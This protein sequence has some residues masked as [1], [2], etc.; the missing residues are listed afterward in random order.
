MAPLFN[1]FNKSGRA[2]GN[3]SRS[4]DRTNTPA[5]DYREPSH[6]AIIYRSELDYISRCILDYP[7]IETGGQLF[8]FWTSTGTPVVTYVIGPGPRARHNHTSFIQ[9]QDY[10]QT[11]GRE[12]HRRYRLQHVG[13]W[14][15]HH[16]LG[17]AHPSGGDVNTMQYGV[18]KPGFPRLL[19]CI[20]N[21]TRTHSTVNPFNFHENTPRHYTEAV[22]DVVDIES[23][24]RRPADNDLRHMLIHPRTAKA[25]HGSIRTAGSTAPSPEGERTHW[26]TEDVANIETL[27][28]FI[29]DAKTLF[30]TDNVKAL[31]LPGGE[32]VIS[33]DDEKISIELPYGFPRKA[34]IARIKDGCNP[35]PGTDALWNPAEEPL[36]S[37][38]AQWLRAAFPVQAKAPEHELAAEQLKAGKRTDLMGIE[39]EHLASLFHNDAFAWSD[40]TDSPVVSIM[41]YPFRKGEQ[42]VIRITIPPQ[43][44]AAMP[45]IQYGSYTETDP[46]HPSL[47]SCLGGI[48]YRPLGELFENCEETYSL[49]LRWEPT[50]SMF[51]AYLV[52]CL[53]LMCKE[54]AVAE[55]R[56][57]SDLTDALLADPAVLENALS[58]IAMQIRIQKPL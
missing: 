16:Q 22:W 56:R 49:M 54:R 23:P 19:L 44:P 34:P 13:E 18:G 17:L 53:L 12:L 48:A 40:I 57:A 43:Y 11:I 51:R 30:G 37:T 25:S 3:S 33:V 28:T 2:S 50:E 36:A 15:S 29:A 9:D 27:K 39:N 5:E 45:Q 38:F 35:I 55:G 32:P 31:I 14:H 10:L 58:Q 41:A 7:D 6:K 21:C 46:R 52:A 24:Y 47:A 42:K 26:L 4:S 1:L 20:G 8:G